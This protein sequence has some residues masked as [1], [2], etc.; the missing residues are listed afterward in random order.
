MITRETMGERPH[1]LLPVDRSSR[2]R[3]KF[4]SFFSADVRV[5]G[6]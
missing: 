1:D 5:L 6:S 4:D 3:G 2:E